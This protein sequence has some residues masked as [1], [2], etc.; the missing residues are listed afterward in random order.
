MLENPRSG[1]RKLHAVPGASSCAFFHSRGLVGLVQ[2]GPRCHV[3]RHKDTD[4]HEERFLARPATQRHSSRTVCLKALVKE[5]GA[6]AG[7]LMVSPART[8]DFWLQQPRSRA[9]LVHLAIRL[10][11]TEVACR[12]P[13]DGTKEREDPS[14]QWKLGA[15]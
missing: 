6:L 10:T 2:I 1:L 12:D 3:G 13:A 4:L 11:S 15:I 9:I 5:C 14:N 7:M 8:T